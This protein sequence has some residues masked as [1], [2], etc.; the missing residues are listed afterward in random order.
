M[1]SN[2]FFRN[3]GQ[4]QEESESLPAL[5]Q[6]KNN[7]WGTALTYGFGFGRRDAIIAQHGEPEKWQKVRVSE[8]VR[9]SGSPK[10]PPGWQKRAWVVAARG[11]L[12]RKGN[13]HSTQPGSR[14][15][16]LTHY[17]KNATQSSADAQT[18][19]FSRL[20]KEILLLSA[21][22]PDLVAAD[23]LAKTQVM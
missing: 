8:R 18:V 14:R 19:N 11:G 22:L 21:R 12:R 6:S 3:I 16:G 10:G 9:V 2:I 5:G 20:A 13:R 1:P 7:C 15:S 23:F 4:K 17:A